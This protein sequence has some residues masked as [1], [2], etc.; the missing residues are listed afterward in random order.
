M[1][2][3]TTLLVTLASSPMGFVGDFEFVGGE[4]EQ[5]EITKQIEV[6]A[7]EVPSLFRSRA[8]SKMEE[9]TKPPAKLTFAKKG[10]ELTITTTHGAITAKT[11]G[12]PAPLANLKEHTVTLTLKGNV[13]TQ[14]T[15]HPK[16]HRSYVYTLTADGKK[17]SVDVEM[18]SKKLKKTTFKYKLSY[19]R[20]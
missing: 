3:T 12:T 8:R 18:Y 20:K 7:K 13:L 19:K 5:S 17:L 14:M 2:L 15:K 9:F 1:I 11:D 6:A 16:G 4:K 10:D